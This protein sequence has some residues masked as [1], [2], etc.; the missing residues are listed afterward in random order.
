VAGAATLDEAREA[1][2]LAEAAPGHAVAFAARVAEQARGEGD[3][4]AGAVAERAWGLALRHSGDLVSAVE[5]LQHAVR[6]GRRSGSAR[7]AGE[8]RI[9][10]AFALFERGRTRRAL[11]EIDAAALELDGAAAALALAQ[12]GTILNEL[13]RVDEAVAC[14][15]AAL[16]VL[17]DSGDSLGVYRV[18]WN[19]GLAHAYRHE[20]AA[21]EADLREAERLAVELGLKVWVGFAQANLAHVL[22]LRGDV[23]AALDYMQR[24]EHRIRAHDA[25]LG[26]LLQDRSELLLSVRLVSEARET[27][28]QAIVE[29]AKE[30]R[31]IKLPEVR[32]L[33]AQAALL[34]GAV[35]DALRQGSRAVREFIR[36]QRP[37][38]AALA[39]LAVLQARC[40]GGRAAAISTRS[41]EQLVA[42]LGAAGWPAAAMEARLLA[43]RLLLDRGHVEA[44]RAHLQQASRLRRRRGPATLRA[45][46]WYAEALVR[47]STGDR[48]SATSAIRA[49]LHVLDEHRAVL[50]AT[51]LRAHAA[52][53]RTDLAELGL[54]IAFQDG[55]P[56]RVFE[57]AERGRASHLLLQ[58]PARPPEDPALAD[59]LAELRGTMLKINELHENRAGGTGLAKL[60][61]R[62][63]SLEQRIRDHSRRQ[64]GEPATQLPGPVPTD[65]LAELLGGRALLEFVQLDGMLYAVSLV[66]GRARLRRLGPV[67]AVD[68][69]LD[70][71]VFALHRLMP[72]DA[73]ADSAAAALGLLGRA[74]ERIDALLLGPVAEIR[75]RPLVVVPTGPLQRLPW[76]VLPS[77]AGRPLTVSPSATLWHAA[78]SRPAE[79]PGHV[80]AAAG[81]TLPG[82]REE[83]QAVAAIHRMTPL[84]H[85]ASTVQAVRAALDGAAVAHLAAHGRLSPHNP[86]FSDLLLS[87]GPLLTYDLEGLD[88]P[89]HT[90][91]LAACDS[92]RAVVCAGDELLGLSATFLTQGTTQL[93]ASVLPVLDA[94][95]APL[96]ATF[97]R[98]LVTGLPPAVALATAQQRVVGD[99]ATMAAAAGFVCLG[100]GFTAPPLRRS[101]RR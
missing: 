85:P 47:S 24:A 76:S 57:W 71:V 10:L 37:E 21:A 84:L 43:A 63:V 3:L 32:L 95:T 7:F 26:R 74:A 11:A 94:E 59:A 55:R 67:T 54:R 79:P 49:G 20:F 60:V 61:Q 27:A 86:L 31:E 93:I 51:D 83:A 89:P 30:R 96:M 80:V 62:Q 44:G 69:L 34:D 23:P 2:R 5:H 52:G 66:D 98:L 22:G 97:H 6:L 90:V 35:A 88:R 64:R 87:D 1:L 100:A 53:H 14:Y 82:A 4:A 78:S 8:A 13:G 38:W 40:A 77:C 46:A 48:R 92:A 9:T 70:R 75:D 16:P 45:R 91:V 56:S 12:R 33:L 29:Y 42:A 50:G 99:Q 36:Q 81:P 72:G 19:R 68:G 73:D 58:R 15:R 101:S 28:E 41:V 18:V 25:Q 39:R 17:R 65:A